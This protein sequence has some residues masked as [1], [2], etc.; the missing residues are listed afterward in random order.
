MPQTTLLV[1]RKKPGNVPLTE[2]LDYLERVEPKAYIACLDFIQQLERFG[3][4]L[5]RPIADKVEG[6]IHELRP[7]VGKVHYRVLYFFCGKNVACMTHGFT[8]E[9]P[10]PPIEIDRANTARKLVE[11]DQDRY[12]ADWEI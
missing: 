8:K 9:G 7:K 4:E 3:H 6:K 10:I 2:W 11:S 5:R 1:Y 12:T